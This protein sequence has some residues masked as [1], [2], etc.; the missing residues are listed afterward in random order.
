MCTYFKEYPATWTSPYECCCTH[1]DNP[2]GDCDR[3]DCPLDEDDPL[4]NSCA[5]P[6]R[7]GCGQCESCMEYG[8]YMYERWKDRIN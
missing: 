2:S 6:G 8:D 4:I 1:K 7:G 3:E 5:N